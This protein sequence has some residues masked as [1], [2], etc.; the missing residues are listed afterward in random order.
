M[1]EQTSVAA[2]PPKVRQPVQYGPRLVAQASYL[3]SY[4]L[5][6]IARATELLGDFYGLKPADAFVPKANEAVERNTLDSLKAIRSQ[7]K[8]VPIGH[9]DESGLKV[10]GKT[11]WVHVASTSRIQSFG[12]IE[13]LLLTYYQ[14]HK[15][16]GQQAMQEIGILPQF[17]GTAM[18]D[19]WAS[20]QTFD[21]CAH[22]YCNA[23]HLRE[24]QFITDQYQQPWA[25]QMSQL[26]LDIK[27]EVEQAAHLAL[28]LLPD[29]IAYFDNRYDEIIQAGK[30]ANQPPPSIGPRQRGRVKQSPAKNLL[31]RLEKHK[32]ETLAFMRDFT[33]PFDNNLAERDIRMIKLK[34]KVSGGF[35][36]QRGAQTFCAVRSYISTVKKHGRQVI[37]AI[38]EALLGNPF[39]PV[40]DA[41]PE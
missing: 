15:K 16:R 18:H 31:D 23:H 9:F 22:A 32:R 6:P 34:Q 37:D 20:Y 4:H 39:I 21:N 33:V 2:F 26:L 7:L 11:Q 1:C 30:A 24:L 8:K 29:R 41:P 36:T 27:S 25:L 17:T 12:M 19:H 14:L 5:I 10:G 38:T 3:N 35:R 28:A 40:P 13:S